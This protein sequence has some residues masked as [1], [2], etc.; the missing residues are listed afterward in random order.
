MSQILADKKRLREL[1]MKKERTEA[2]QY[3][4]DKAP[5]NIDEMK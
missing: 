3:A 2:V 4:H 5:R 1:F